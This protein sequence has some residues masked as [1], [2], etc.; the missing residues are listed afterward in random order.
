MVKCKDHDE[1]ERFMIDIIYLIEYVL[2]D[3]KSKALM[4]IYLYIIKIIYIVVQIAQ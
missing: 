4:S 1:Q 2:I 3:I